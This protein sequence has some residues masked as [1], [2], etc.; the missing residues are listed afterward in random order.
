MFCVRNAKGMR[1][2]E[3]LVTADGKLQNVIVYVRSGHQGRSYSAPTEPVLLDQQRCV[4]TPHVFTIMTNQKLRIRNSDD[5]FHNVRGKTEVNSPF[6]IGQP[7]IGAENTE[8]FTRPEI[9][10]RIGCDMHP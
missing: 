4:Y 6:N 5:T 10:A 7:V 3:V 2:Q 8:I 1:S 9:P